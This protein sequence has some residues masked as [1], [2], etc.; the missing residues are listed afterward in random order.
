MAIIEKQLKGDNLCNTSCIEQK[1]IIHPETD[2]DAVLM[3]KEDTSSISL[4]DWILGDL[5]DTPSVQTSLK[6]WLDAYYSGEVYYTLPT[7]SSN[8]KGGI[9][10]GQYLTIN[11]EILSV[12]KNALNIPNEY[13]LPSASHVDNNYVL[14]GVNIYTELQGKANPSDEKEE[15]IS[16]EYGGF[17]E[18]EEKYKYTSIF[19]IPTEGQEYLTFDEFYTLPV[20]IIKE[21]VDNNNIIVNIPKLLFEWDNIRNTPSLSQV[22]LSG[23]YNDLTNKPTIPAAQIQSDWT[24]S[25]NTSKDFIQHKPTI[26]FEV[27]ED[28]PED[29]STL[30]DILYTGIPIL[31][32][33]QDDI[34]TIL[35]NLL[36]KTG[37]NQIILYVSNNSGGDFTT[38]SI[39]FTGELTCLKNINNSFYYEID[40]SDGEYDITFTFTPD[41]TTKIE[42]FRKEIED[43]VYYTLYVNELESAQKVN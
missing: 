42:Y 33:T 6:G 30:T 14:G 15:G 17:I 13:I 10:V 4:K 25:D 38:N 40:G 32:I 43:D 35:E 19:R 20:D 37:I 2:I 1:E 18:A 22:A 29:I 41:I 28:L 5:Q 16:I 27:L 31:Q 39:H 26:K 23:S 24:Q 21:G 12:D 9:K 3:S 36:T 11:N 7:A 8:V 34:Q